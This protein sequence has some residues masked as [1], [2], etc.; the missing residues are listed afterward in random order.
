MSKLEV[1]AG[2]NRKVRDYIEFV[3]DKDK[4][5]SSVGYI[6][7][8]EEVKLVDWA[9]PGSVKFFMRWPMPLAQT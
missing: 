9:R 1:C 6:G 3:Y 5:S 8:R 4:C 2:L 7:G